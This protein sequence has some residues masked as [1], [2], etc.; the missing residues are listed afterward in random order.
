MRH[1]RRLWIPGSASQPRDDGFGAKIGR[2]Q[3]NNGI[4]Y[5]IA[6]PKRKRP[7]NSPGLPY[8][9]RSEKTYSAAAVFAADLAAFSAL[10]SSL[11][12]LTGWLSFEPSR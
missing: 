5:Q 4:R 1:L 8:S 7:G 2:P 3:L 10:S 12:V 11:D 9:S 6:D